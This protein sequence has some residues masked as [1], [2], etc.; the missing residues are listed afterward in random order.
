MS[1]QI[2]EI[3]IYASDGRRRRLKFHIGKV[4]IITGRSGTGK[5]ALI[6]IIDYCFGRSTFTIPEGVIRDTV[7]WYAVLLS[8]RQGTDIFIAKPAPGS[9]A[10]SQSK[11]MISI[12][13]RLEPPEFREL[14]I[15]SNDAAVESQ[16]SRELG[17]SPNL[18][19]PEEG[20][21]RLPLRANISHAKFYMFQEQGII[22]NRDLLFFRQSEPFI[23]QAIKD[24]LPYFLGAVEEDQLAKLEE[25]RRLRREIKLMERDVAERHA[26]VGGG[27]QTARS[28]LAEAMQVGLTVPRLIG[29][30]ATELHGVL[31]GL[32]SWQ[33]ADIPDVGAQ[34]G[35]QI[36]AHLK[37][38]RNV[39]R[40]LA[41]A[42][43][44]A[45]AF[46]DSASGYTFEVREQ[47]SRLESIGLINASSEAASCPFCGNKSESLAPAAEQLASRLATLDEQ[48]TT[49][50][51][52]KP[53]LVDHMN[54][55]AERQA[56][57]RQEIREN[58]AE[59]VAVE[60]E[61]ARA[62]AIA[63]QN[64]RIA[65]VL[66]RISLYLEN[67]MVTDTGDA[68]SLELEGK[69]TLARQL[70]ALVDRSEG[71]D[72]LAS[73]LN[74]VSND[75]TK[76]ASR[77]PFEH[78]DHPL[79]FDFRNLTVIADRPGRPF[80]MQRMGSGQNWLVCHL[81]TLLA[82]HRHFRVENR[83]VP[84]ILVLDQPSQVYF[85]SAERY[86]DADGSVE[87]T[88]SSGADIS[89]VKRMFSLLFDL[90]T[91]LKGELQLIVLEHA[92]LDSEQYQAAL[93]EE[94]WDGDAHALVP[95]SWVKPGK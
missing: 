81:V 91:E 95:P 38:L 12:G 20:Q 77:L 19:M 22:A 55:I 34:R 60:R 82:L 31:R 74:R 72:V 41:E 7:A 66:G 28:L 45:L 90:V 93:V 3:V 26:V 18:N 16:L 5:S 10:S 83:P 11:S 88:E 87:R 32:E 33:P 59:L 8:V 80:T 54:A 13:S 79:R 61:D 58:Q 37:S 75:M 40:D 35:P 85:P 63:D 27:I 48:L 29:S 2:K 84:G 51:H 76:L 14:L 46:S 86:R 49:V 57:I 6:P 44:A 4:N 78:H 65:R 17:I 68:I 21:S 70:E 24:T 92:N 15:N 89:A 62:E 69:R 53:H 71:L 73:M 47:A 30:T 25:L 1:L 56:A 9:S 64:S 67:A 43:Q 50:S 23:P 52:Q 94:R 42:E 39:L 36:R